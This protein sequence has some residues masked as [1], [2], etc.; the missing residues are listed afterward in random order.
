MR[1]RIEELELK[2]LNTR[3]A[4]SPEVIPRVQVQLEQETRQLKSQYEDI[5]TRMKLEAPAFAA[6]YTTDALSLD[7]IQKL[8]DTQ[9]TLVSYYFAKGRI[10]VFVVTSK[11]FRCLEL[12]ATEADVQK[13]IA[14]FRDFASL[15]DPM[16]ATR[17][18]LYQM[19][20]KPIR[21]DLK[22]PRLYIV[23]HGALHYLPFS[24]LTDGRKLLDEA[25]TI[26]YLPSA[27][28]LKLLPVSGVKSG[29]LLALSYGEPIGFPSLPFSDATARD[30]AALFGT[31]A[32]IGSAAVPS[33][34]SR[35]LHDQSTVLL[36]AHAKLDS[37]HPLFSSIILAPEA[38][39]PTGF[40]DI[41]RIYELDM[42]HVQLVVLSACS[43]QLGP[44]SN[45]DDFVALNRAFMYA[46]V[47]NV[48]ASLWSVADRQTGE[49]M[50]LFFK[51]IQSGS[52]PAAALR[53]AQAEFRL[54]WPHPYYWAGFLVNGRQ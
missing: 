26:A 34:L 51:R 54:R 42:A 11:S 14:Q 53:S 9:T 18:E 21:S 20:V 47:R 10:V 3:G 8:L 24:A 25:F 33:A 31:R 40:L 5:L 48:V 15:S 37:E 41:K 43:T 23:P 13:R 49:L 32:L 19:L 36:S 30:A 12:T 45:G 50:Q 6:L 22:T 2:A 29:G 1:Q 17:E 35:D 46:G 16:A 38:G 7:G 28:M 27:T 52:P 39:A 4:A 44:R